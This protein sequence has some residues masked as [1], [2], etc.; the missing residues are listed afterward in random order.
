MLLGLFSLSLSQRVIL[1][2]VGRQTVALLHL[3]ESLR[4]VDSQHVELRFRHC[5]QFLHVLLYLLLSQLWRFICKH[6][7]FELVLYSQQVIKRLFLLNLV[8]NV[9]TCSLQLGESRSDLSFVKKLGVEGIRKSEAWLRREETTLLGNALGDCQEFK[10]Y[11]YYYYYKLRVFIEKLM[12][13]HESTGYIEYKRYAASLI[14][15]QIYIN[16]N[17]N[18]TK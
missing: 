11:Y 15:H 9:G 3:L 7:V 6:E 12:I 14:R 4:E 10:H 8:T 2:S 18:H 16:I 1:L 17:S 13:L 5:E